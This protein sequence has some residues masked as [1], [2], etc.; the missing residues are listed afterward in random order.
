MYQN[1][2]QQKE[3]QQRRSLIIAGIIIV[4]A[5]VF[6]LVLAATQA[7][8]SPTNSGGS[9]GGGVIPGNPGDAMGIEIPAQCEKVIDGVCSVSLGFDAGGNNFAYYQE[10]T[11]SIV[12]AD[13]LG[14]VIHRQRNVQSKSSAMFI[15]GTLY[16]NNIPVWRSR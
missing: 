16:V 8:T 2:R 6:T 11:K 14:N 10:T 15:N 3:A 12:I 7:P 9:G 1:K 5:T 4:V 13:V